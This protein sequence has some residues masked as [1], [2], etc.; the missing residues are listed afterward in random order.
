M[1]RCH[2]KT[3]EIYKYESFAKKLNNELMVILNEPI[4]V[5]RDPDGYRIWNILYCLDNIQIGCYIGLSKQR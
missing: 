4:S 5:K 2:F 1:K 3:L